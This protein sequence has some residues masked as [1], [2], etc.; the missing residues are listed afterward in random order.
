MGKIDGW[1]SFLHPQCMWVCML[2]LLRALHFR[3][4]KS[5]KKPV[6]EA[7]PCPQGRCHLLL[8]KMRL[9]GPGCVAT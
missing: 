5:V 7:W 2:C 1:V 9:G 4:L 3:L 6:K 8:S